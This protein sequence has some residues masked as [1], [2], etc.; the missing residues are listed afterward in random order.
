MSSSTEAVA[1]GWVEA[2]A[3]RAQPDPWLRRWL[4]ADAIA[5]KVVAGIVDSAADLSGPAIARALADA[6]PPGALLVVGSSASARDLDLADPWDDP[7][8]V[9]ANRG[10]SGIDGTV[11]TAIGAALAHGGDA[12]A[13][14]G[15]LTFLH[16][17]HRPGDR[18]GRAAPRPDD[19]GQQRRRRRHLRSARAGCPRARRAVRAVVRHVARRRHRVVVRGDADA[20]QAGEQHR[21]AARSPSSAC[22]PEL[23][24]ARGIRVVEVRTD[25]SRRR[26]LDRRLREDV[27]AALRS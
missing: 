5:S 8:L 15:D 21:R 20:A 13:L 6:L 25:R 7:R 24:S 2:A 23:A 9:L 3:P 14:L 4:D 18:A 1:P 10:A 12:F 16:D 26:D 19:R 22:A 27:A 17:S 11:S